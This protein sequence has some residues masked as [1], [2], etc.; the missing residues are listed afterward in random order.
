MKKFILICLLSLAALIPQ[1]HAQQFSVRT[2]A[3]GWAALGTMN[4]GAELAL[5][6]RWTV[7]A[8]VLWNPWVY[9]NGKQTKMWGIQPEVRFWCCRKFT[10]HFVG[11]HTMYAD[12]DFGLDKYRYNGWLSGLGVSYGYSW[13]FSDHWRLEGNIGLGWLHK[14]YDREG[15]AQRTGDVRIY[16]S[17]RKD[18]FGITRAGISI[19]YLIFN[20]KKR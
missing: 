7:T 19:S 2:N 18:G 1:A 15:R 14:D 11:L 3:L 6:P 17:Q 13:A 12:Y 4:L 9:G 8:D 16:S 20:K 10:G 5:A